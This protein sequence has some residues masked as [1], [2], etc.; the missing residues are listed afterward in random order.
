MTALPAERD[1]ELVETPD[2]DTIVL[3]D[4]E[5]ES[6]KS[7]RRYGINIR[8]DSVIRLTLT[9]PAVANHQQAGNRVPSQTPVDLR[10][11]AAKMLAPERRARP[12]RLRYSE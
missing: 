3:G 8:S 9:G 2:N 1:L 5:D 11:K 4:T 12:P 6:A 7:A 10:T